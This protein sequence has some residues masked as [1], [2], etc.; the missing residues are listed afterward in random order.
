[1]D[2][3]A[4]VLGQGIHHY[5]LITAEKEIL[6][7]TLQGIIK[8]LTDLLSLLNPEAFGRASR[9][10]RYA[11]NLATHMGIEEIWKIETA[12][13][14]SQVGCLM[15]PEETL[16]KVYQGQ[17]LTE[18]EA[19][20]FRTHPH[21]ASQLL[22]NIPRMQEIAEIINYQEKNFDGSGLPNNRREGAAIPIGARI[23]K[24]ILD[25]DLLESRGALKGKALG[26]L[27]QRPGRYDP[28]VLE[29]LKEALGDEAKYV[30]RLIPIQ[31]LKTHMIFSEDVT[32][33]KGQLLVSR[34]QEVSPVLL[35]RLKTFAVNAG[36]KEPIRVFVPFQMDV[37]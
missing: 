19:Y 6:E 14:L 18:E 34:G 20:N 3:L 30:V 37:E 7:K 17:K 31:G 15:L 21:L 8:M 11:V 9:I 2:L 29:A 36:V 28:L 33:L 24:V 25:F 27:K 23:L 4:K 10:R 32:T 1:M 12:A 13:L 5:H 35:Q 22:S 16:R 26:E